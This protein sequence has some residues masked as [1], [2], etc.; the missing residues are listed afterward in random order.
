MQGSQCLSHYICAQ[1]AQGSLYTLKILVKLLLLFLVLHYLLREI[2]V[3]L[4]VKAQQPKEQR[5][6]VLSVC[7]VF[8]RVQAM[9]RPAVLGIF[10]VHT[11]VDAC[12]C[13]PGAV[14]T[15]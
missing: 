7:A 14:R 6:P 13:T 15:P 12:D 5:Y 3:A 2:R 10:N 11:N 9:V 4:P 8:S 1:H